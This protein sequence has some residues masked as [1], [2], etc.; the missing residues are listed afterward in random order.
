MLPGKAAISAADQELSAFTE[1]YD[2]KA[3]A[4]EAA[5]A[6]ADPVA[7]AA[8]VEEAFKAIK[9]SF[10][11]Y[12]K[13]SV[14]TQLHTLFH[15]KC[16]YCETFY[17]AVAPVDVEHYRPKGAVN[18]DVTHPGYWW[19]AM[20][21]DNLLPSCIHCNRLNQHVT[22]RFSTQL[23]ELTADS[24]AFSNQHT[25]T[26]GKGNHFPILGVRATPT[27]RDYSA[28][29]PLLL[30]P[31]VDDPQEHLA[32]HVDRQNLIGLVLPKPHTGAGLPKDISAKDLLP[33]FADEIDQAFRRQLSLRGAVS[34]YTYGLNRLGL[35]QDRTRV[36]RHLVFLEESM[37]ELCKT[38]QCL[39]DRENDPFEEANKSI[40]ERLRA[41]VER[42]AQQMADM[43]KPQAPYSTMVSEF[44]QS[45]E[46]RLNNTP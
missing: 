10:D 40:I 1:Y 29:Y 21:W 14:K 18:Q 33:K 27:S 39:E 45:L 35:V 32:Y 28:E 34:I 8:S 26:T 24:R 23:V 31:C 3:A 36:L 2:K 41:L 37:K 15:G 20:D 38:I 6:A 13:D 9:P 19:L 25:V 11:T 5:L 12:R 16:A 17:P 30:N 22:P 44:L 7:A 46:A 4:L 43:A 42:I